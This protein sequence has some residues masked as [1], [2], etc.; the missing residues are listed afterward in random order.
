MTIHA[1][2]PYMGAYPWNLRVQK[3]Y[4]N[5]FGWQIA[6]EPSRF[7]RSLEEA[8]EYVFQRAQ[9]CHDKSHSEYVVGLIE[10]EYQGIRFRDPLLHHSRRIIAE[11]EGK[12]L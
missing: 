9:A 11:A 1:D 6:I 4:R 2:K 7:F 12:S 8:D 5:H 10:H 3:Y